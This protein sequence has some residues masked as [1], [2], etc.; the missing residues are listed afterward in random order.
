MYTSSESFLY[1]NDKNNYCIN[2]VF[3]INYPLIRFLFIVLEVW[4]RLANCN[5]SSAPVKLVGLFFKS[6]FNDFV[7]VNCSI[8]AGKELNE[9]CRTHQQCTGTDN[10]NSCRLVGNTSKCSCDDKFDLMDGKCLK[11]KIHI[12]KTSI[13]MNKLYWFEGNE[14]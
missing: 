13:I 10:A 14:S 6:S 7:Y 1:N 12:K 4:S 2:Y 5:A 8:V 3:E 11:S 9:M